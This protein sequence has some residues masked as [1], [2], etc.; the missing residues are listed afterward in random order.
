MKFSN[1][2]NEGYGSQMARGQRDWDR[3]HAHSKKRYGGASDEPR[4]ETEAQTQARLAKDTEYQAKL[5]AQREKD[6]EDA[7]EK[8]SDKPNE[9]ETELNKSRVAA[10][11]KKIDSIA[12][13]IRLEDTLGADGR[14]TT[15]LYNQKK[16]YTH[17]M[18]YYASLARGADARRPK[19]EAPKLQLKE[20]EE[21][22][23][24]LNAQYQR[25]LALKKKRE[26][27]KKKIAANK[28]K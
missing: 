11:K 5:K 14:D 25:E 13:T 2:V 10:L 15:A 12:H 18:N 8:D 3:A 9:Q 19:G 21:K 4:G 23:V 27:L 22:E 16:N 17:W 6:Y 26:E 24:D 20:S 7:H 28:A 1:F